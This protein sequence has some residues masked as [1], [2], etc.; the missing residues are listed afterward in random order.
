MVT[1]RQHPVGAADCFIIRIAG[2]AK[3]NVEIHAASSHL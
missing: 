1:A 2:N 3:N